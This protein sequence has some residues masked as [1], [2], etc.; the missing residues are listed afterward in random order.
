VAEEDRLEAASFRVGDLEIE[1]MRPLEDDSP[2]GRFIARRGE[3]IHHIAYRVDDVDESLRAARE[4]GVETIDERARTGGGGRTRV[5]FLH[6]KATFG[7]LTRAVW[8]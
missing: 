7:V 2:V 5:G 8:S 1:L 6:P 3:G 4:A